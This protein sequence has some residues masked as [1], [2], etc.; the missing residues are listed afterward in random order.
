MLRGKIFKVME[1]SGN[2]VLS[3]ENWHCNSIGI[4]MIFFLIK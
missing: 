3:K 2:F 4:S 1:E